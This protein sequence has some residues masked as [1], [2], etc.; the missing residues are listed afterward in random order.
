MLDDGA[1]LNDDK[2]DAPVVPN[3]ESFSTSVPL[4]RL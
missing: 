4:V 1:W 3:V 2:L